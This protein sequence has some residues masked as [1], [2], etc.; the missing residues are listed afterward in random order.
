[1]Y[2]SNFFVHLFQISGILLLALGTWIF[3]DL[4]K[5]HLIALLTPPDSSKELV[6]YIAYVLLVLGS[7]ILIAGILG[8]C[9]ALQESRCLLI[10]YFALLV[11][12]LI[13]EFAVGVVAL[14]SR[15]KYL[16]GMQGRLLYQLSTSYGL[17]GANYSAF[18]EAM[19]LA[20]Y[21]FDCCGVQAPEDYQRS[22][23][24][25]DSSIS[26]EPRNVPP[27]CCVLSNHEVTTAG[28]PLSVVSRV[29][30]GTVEEAWQSPQPRDEAACQKGA[31]GARHNQM[32]SSDEYVDML[33]IYGEARQN[34]YQHNAYTKNDIWIDDNQQASHFRLWK[35]T[36]RILHPWEGH[37][38]FEIIP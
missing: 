5:A 35:D 15:M 11:I 25:N 13:G 7:V 26:N 18:T 29:F 19:D 32:Y 30:G 23:W 21:K 31:N 9:G 36:C 14:S 10:T 33:L 6:F 4:T 17:H 1:M 20:Q 8:C 3:I 22:R 34:V 38:L 16:S 24:W 12:L 2:G 27:T 28:S 37:G